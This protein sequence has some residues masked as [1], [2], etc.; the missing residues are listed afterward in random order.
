MFCFDIRLP[1]FFRTVLSSI[2]RTPDPCGN[3]MLFLADCISIDCCGGKLS[4]R[5]PFL[6]HVQRDTFDGGIDPESMPQAFWTAMR[7]MGYPRFDHDRFGDLPHAHATDRPDWRVGLFFRFL[8]FSDAVG[9][10][11]CVQLS[12]RHGNGPVDDP[13]PARSVFAFLKTA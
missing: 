6:Q 4:M 8:G 13:G 1:W 3:V 5:H 2:G 11:E 7:G 9:G 10:V 12:G